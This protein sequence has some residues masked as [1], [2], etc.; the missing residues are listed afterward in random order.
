MAVAGVERQLRG[1]NGATQQ[2]GVDDVRQDASLGEQLATADCLGNALVV[3]I[4][5]DP[6]GEQVLRVPLA[7]AMAQ[8]D[9]GV[10]GIR[11]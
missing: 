2:R 10:R 4:D 11:G 6:A 1:S 7:F 8:E 3:Q 5:I 9:E